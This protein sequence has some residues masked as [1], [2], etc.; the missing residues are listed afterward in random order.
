MMSDRNYPAGPQARVYFRDWTWGTL[1]VQLLAFGIGL[2]A[3][4]KF[5]AVA[6]N[7]TPSYEMMS[8]NSWGEVLGAMRTPG[9]PVFL[10]TLRAT[11]SHPTWIPVGHFVAYSLGVMFFSPAY[12]D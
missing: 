4:G 1:I 8:W 11:S 5:E 3:T 7:D 2:A 10:S 9:Y 12:V 6:T